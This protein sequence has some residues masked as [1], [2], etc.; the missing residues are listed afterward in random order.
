MMKITNNRMMDYC[1]IFGLTIGMSIL[2]Q[3][4]WVNVL[5]SN[6]VVYVQGGGVQRFLLKIFSLSLIYASL[7]KSFSINALRFNFVFKIPLLYYM[8][9]VI[10]MIPYTYNNA[11]ILS[12]NLVLFVPL[13]C[14]VLTGEKGKFIYKKLIKIIVGVVC[15]QL[16]ADLII[17][18]LGLNL[19]G[20]VLGGM[21]NA[22]TFGIHLITAALGLRFIYKQNLLSN[23]MLIMVWGTGSLVC[24]G[25]AAALLLQSVIIGFRHNIFSTVLLL[26]GVM[27]GFYFWGDGILFGEVG[28]LWHAFMKIE[29]LVN[30][31][32]YGSDLFNEGVGSITG[33]HK[34]TIE[35]LQLIS[36]NPLSLFFGHPNYLPFYSGDGFYIAMLV[37]LGLPA[38]LLFIISNFY[39][40]YRGLSE[41]TP[42]SNFSAYVLFTYILFFTV[43][44]ILDYWPSGLIYII[45]FNYLLRARRLQN[46]ANKV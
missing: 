33:R 35:G 13:L 40:V 45:V 34:Y 20:T 14:L 1:L 41:N 31:I 3:I 11:Y 39:A 6:G 18:G 17:K 44:R 5:V 46:T 26:V 4:Y 19:I 22:N 27:M 38:T 43:N 25:I 9:T 37:T 2:F 32:Y 10:M 29:G 23:I 12:V 28:P 36:E 16:V 42:L 7:Y 21:G 24:V 15:L 8:V 30:V